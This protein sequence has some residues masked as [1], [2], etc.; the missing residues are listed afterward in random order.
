MSLPLNI[1]IEQA[2]DIIHADIERIEK[3]YDLPYTV[4]TLLIESE[5]SKRKEAELAA[6]SRAISATNEAE[7]TEE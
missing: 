7:E 1:R 4:M 2:R 5:I 3:M 6:V